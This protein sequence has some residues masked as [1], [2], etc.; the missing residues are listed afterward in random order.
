MQPKPAV[1]YVPPPSAPMRAAEDIPAHVFVARGPGDTAVVA[2]TG[3][4][5]VAVS[6]VRILKG[7][8]VNCDP[9]TGGNAATQN[10]RHVPLRLGADATT[11]AHLTPD[12][13]GYGVPGVVG[14]DPVGGRCQEGRPAG[15]TAPVEVDL[16]GLNR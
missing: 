16:L 6:R 14:Q 7:D 9:A 12:D 4:Q 11:G 1:V 8:V 13:N 15:D 10:A 5:P 3:T 2:R